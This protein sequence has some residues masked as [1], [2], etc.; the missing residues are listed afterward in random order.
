MFLRRFWEKLI[1]FF[2]LIFNYLPDTET[3]SYAEIFRD[4]GNFRGRHHINAKLTSLVDGTHPF[5]LLLATFGFAFV[6]IYDSDTKIG[7]FHFELG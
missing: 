4:K 6:R 3:T 5:T 2:L 1:F 7:V